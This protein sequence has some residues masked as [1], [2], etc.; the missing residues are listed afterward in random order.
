MRLHS[1]SGILASEFQKKMGI[2]YLKDFIKL[3]IIP[4]NISV[5][6]DWDWPY[7]K[8]WLICG[9]GKSGMSQNQTKGPP[10]SS[11]THSHNSPSSRKI[12]RTGITKNSLILPVKLF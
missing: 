5:V 3:K 4:R 10:F 9:M 7:V 11:H 12:I 8:H 6:R 2:K 1:M